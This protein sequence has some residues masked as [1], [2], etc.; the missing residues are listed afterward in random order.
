MESERN[1]TLDRQTLYCV[2]IP[3]ESSWV[4]E[5]YTSHS[6]THTQP[7]T[8]YSSIRSKRPLEEEDDTIVMEQAPVEKPQ[9]MDMESDAAAAGGDGKKTKT[10]VKQGRGLIYF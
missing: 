1:V 7:S 9:E 6:E 3:G 10:G 2:P 4:K 8:S 5:A